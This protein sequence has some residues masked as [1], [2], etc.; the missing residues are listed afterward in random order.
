MVRLSGE[1][2]ILMVSVDRILKYCKLKQE[3]SHRTPECNQISVKPLKRSNGRIKF[4]QVCFKYS[5]DLPYSLIDVSLDIRPGEKVGIIGRTGAGKSS[6]FS[7][8]FLLN[9]IS[10][11]SITIDDEDISSLNLFQHRKRL[12]IIPQDPFLFTG[13]L[14]YNVD[15][16]E[17]FTSEEIWDA[18]TKSHLYNM[19][20]SLPDQ[21]ITS[22]AEDGHNFSAGERQLLC[23]TRAILRKNRIILIDEATANVDMRTDALVQ[24]AIRSHLSDCSVLTIA[25]RIETIIDS[26]RI[27]V[28][29]RG[30]IIETDAPFLMLERGTSYLSLL[31][32]QFDPSTE[33]QLRNAARMSFFNGDSQ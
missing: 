13:T 8:L 31:L 11:G 6:L 7:S 4:N 22:V 2:D 32:S 15:P 9:G 5:K 16:F 17:E 27:V 14:R 30:K 19:V 23:L 28:L 29:E 33:Q 20:Q 1:V 26:D 21:L 24:Q 12:S 25:H 10:A 18:L 3:K